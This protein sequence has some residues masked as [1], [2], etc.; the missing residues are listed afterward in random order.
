MHKLKANLGK[1]ECYLYLEAMYLLC[2]EVTYCTSF[3][4][5]CIE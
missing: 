3:S 2:L 1:R 5:E 4:V